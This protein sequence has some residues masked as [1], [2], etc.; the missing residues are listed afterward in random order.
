MLCIWEREW[1]SRRRL[2]MKKG[3]PITCLTSTVSHWGGGRGIGMGRSGSN[4]GFALGNGVDVR[5][6]DEGVGVRG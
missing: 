4:G 5:R 3:S 6:G 1:G 2:A